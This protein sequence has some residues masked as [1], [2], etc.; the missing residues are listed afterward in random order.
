MRISAVFSHARGL[1]DRLLGYLTPAYV[2]SIAALFAAYFITGQF[3]L[4]VLPVHTYATLLWPPS[5]IALA[6]IVLWG[7][8][9]WPAVALGAFAINISL[10]APFPAALCIALGNT[11]EA[12]GGAYLMKEVADFD[13]Y[14]SR[15]RDSIG[16]V[17]F[18]A[19]MA[20]A[21]AA[22][23][24]VVSLLLGNTLGVRDISMTWTTW[25]I[26]DA[27]SI[28]SLSPFLLKWLSHLRFRRTLSQWAEGAA[29]MA[30][31]GVLTALAAW[32]P[33]TTLASVPL[34]YVLLLA[35]II[36]ALRAG[37]RGITLIIFLMTMIALSG[38]LYGVGP[39]AHNI[40]MQEIL[41]TEVFLGIIYI[42]FLL[43]TSVIEERK[44]AGIAMR[45]HIEQLERALERER[46]ADASKNEFI[47]TLG[48]ELRNP[49]SPIVSA[50][51]LLR[52]EGLAA[53]D[54]PQM[55][56]IIESHTTT[57]ARLLDDL[58]DITRITRK[59]FKLRT[60]T[61]DLRE[62]AKRAVESVNAF[63]SSRGHALTTSFPEEPLWLPADP[64]RLHQ[65]FTNLLF[66]AVKYTEPGGRIQ[67]SIARHGEHMARI[68]VRDT[69]IGIEEHMLQKI[70]EP[71]IQETRANS[72]GSGLGL[73]LALTKRLVELHGGA[74]WAESAGIGRGS[75][76]IIELPVP[77]HLQLPMK[78]APP[79]SRAAPVKAGRPLS[80]L[81]VDDNEAA[82]AGLAALL[83]HGGFE[84]ST[85][86]DGPQGLTA[87][88]RRVPDV[89]LL[90]IGLPGMTGYEVA[91]TILAEFRP[92]PVLVALSGYGQEEDKR[93]AREA[94]FAY[95]LTKPVSIVDIEAILRRI[96]GRS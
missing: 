8:S 31:V 45:G 36:A 19:F 84:V 91:K 18:G 75:G 3:G 58:L 66:N 89:V 70:F 35:L 1:P 5:G 86:H 39:I 42:I 63:A 92:A 57:M 74:I 44:E 53:P 21:I 52:R 11:L 27:F 73:G 64:V 51:E 4:N 59:K 25:W 62:I 90:D 82:A 9:L 93:A 16:L 49:L 71:F 6:A 32:T 38:A 80:V 37:P 77:E 96:P 48:H 2:A 7:Y 22:T 79:E 30:S 43:F 50:I 41:N 47:A 12:L 85:A 46:I 33:F 65:A 26:G 28:L 68:C 69:G 17:A 72:T 10:G 60:E 55:L 61:I 34:V 29:I 15:L 88:R 54:A 95:H 56:S 13:P 24:G 67:F 81:V 40:S 14:F 76:F 23:V 20:S 94:G 78:T 83:K 87:L